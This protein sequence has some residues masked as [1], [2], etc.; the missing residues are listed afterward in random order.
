MKRPEHTGEV[1]Y[2]GDIWAK[3]VVACYVH[4]RGGVWFVVE[5]DKNTDIGFGWAEIVPGGGE[6]GSFSLLELED[7]HAGLAYTNKTVQH[8]LREAVDEYLADQTTE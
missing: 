2:G 8:T 7:V 5:Y 6:L 4:L 3:P 1:T